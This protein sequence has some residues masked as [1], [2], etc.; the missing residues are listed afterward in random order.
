M[1]GGENLGRV[2]EDAWAQISIEELIEQDPDVIVLGDAVW[3]G[4][5]V[6][7]VAARSGWENLTAVREDRVYPF[8]DNL[9]SRP[10]PRMVDGLEEIARLLHPDRFE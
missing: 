9:V 2:L 8:D 3:G 1:A 10:G 6:E 7:A 4:I 5:T